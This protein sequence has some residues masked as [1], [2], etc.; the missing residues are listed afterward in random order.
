VSNLLGKIHHQPWAKFKSIFFT[1]NN[2]E[3]ER[4]RVGRGRK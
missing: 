1:P 3:K 2:K 4:E